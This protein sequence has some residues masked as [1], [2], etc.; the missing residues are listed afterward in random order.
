MLE[1]AR[2]VGFPC[3]AVDIEVESERK[4]WVQFYDRIGDDE[5]S[6]C[7]FGRNG[8]FSIHLTHLLSKIELVYI[9]ILLLTTT[10]SRFRHKEVVGPEELLDWLRSSSIANKTLVGTI[11]FKE[12]ITDAIPCRN[13]FSVL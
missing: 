2:H 11:A 3:T 5:S 10:A 4:L 12:D 9:V 8:R 1:S 7:E 13:P 6:G